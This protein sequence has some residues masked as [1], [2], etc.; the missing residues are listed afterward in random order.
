MPENLCPHGRKICSECQHV[1]D[2]GKRAFD[3]I[4]GLTVFTPYDERIRSWVAIRMEDGG[5]DQQLYDSKADAIAHQAWEQ[6]CAYFSFRGAP[7]GFSS[8]KDA[9]IWLE[10]HRLM[11][12][13]GM[14]LA[15]PDDPD[16]IMPTTKEQLGDQLRRLR[17]GM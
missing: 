4:R 13:A 3:I 6:Q 12:S 9:A 5:S 2:A 7:E 8:A 11:Y 10:Y 16:V 14:R 1:S 15:D 17:A